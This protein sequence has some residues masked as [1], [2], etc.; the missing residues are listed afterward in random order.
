MPHQ[1]S[2]AGALRS[3]PTIEIVRRLR[4]G[5]ATAREE[6][7]RRYLPVLQRWARGRLP[8]AARDVSDTDDLVQ[9]TLLR[10]LKNIDSLRLE[11]PGSFFLYLKQ[12]VLNSIRNEIRRSRSQREQ[13]TVHL[14]SLEDVPDS[15]ARLEEIYSDLDVYERALSLL[16]KRQQRLLVMRLEF[17]LSYDEIAIECH[18]SADAARMMVTRA[19]VRLAKETTNF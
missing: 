5:D 3:E 19:I 7:V 15:A 11:R 13:S 17:G 10:A 4:L 12:I 16:P 6:L 1:E 18:S 14:I 2:V 8:D 9:I